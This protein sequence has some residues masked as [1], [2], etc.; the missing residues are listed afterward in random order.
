LTDILLANDAELKLFHQKRGTKV[1]PPSND[2]NEL[3]EKGSNGNKGIMG[4]GSGH[5]Y[6]DP[7]ETGNYS[8]REG[9][10]EGVMEI[11]D[12]VTADAAFDDFLLLRGSLVDIK[13]LAVRMGKVG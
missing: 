2:N 5:A 1:I 8:H 4:L 3:D 9:H 13:R 7:D 10:L 11:L 6:L 12:G